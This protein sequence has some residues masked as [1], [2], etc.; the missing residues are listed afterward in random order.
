VD[1]VVLDL[2]GTLV[3]A[4]TPAERSH[5]ATR[6]ARVIGCDPPDVEDYFLAAWQVRHDGTLAAV[7]ALAAHLIRAVGGRDSVV[8]PVV[9]ELCD[10]GR[11]RLVPDTS[12]VQTLISL[13]SKGFRLG[14]L[15]DASAEIVAT[16]PTGRLATVVDAA[17]F[18]C[19][20]GRTKPDQRLYARVSGELGVPARR[21][22][23]CGDGGG[24]E[25]HGAL[26]H[27]MIVVGVRRRGPANTLAFGD[28]E[29]SGA[30][31]DT[32]EQ[33][34]TYLAELR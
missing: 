25:L 7:S 18:S 21:T 19:A 32:V 22:L 29:W 17:V 23:Y 9:H 24:D 33:L 16:W 31:I 14:V 30:T 5:A 13:R 20:A 12:V 3:G 1:A 28:T 6:L 27:G 10:L 11:A 26:D 15:S 4:P 34:P 8:D 2:F